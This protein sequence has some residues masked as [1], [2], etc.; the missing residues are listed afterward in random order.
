ME[1][2][3]HA[4]LPSGFDYPRAFIRVVELGIV[5]LDPWVVLSAD[6]LRRK[7][8]GL[9]ERY[10]ERRLVPF[11][12]REDRDDVACWDLDGGDVVVIHDFASPGWED[13]QHFPDFVAWFKVAIDEMLDWED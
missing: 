13:R 1:L 3:S 10:P 12:S 8:A 4:D 9:S 2:L 7:M 11:A 6:E 5:D